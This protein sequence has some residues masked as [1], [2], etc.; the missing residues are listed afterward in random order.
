[1]GSAPRPDGKRGVDVKSVVLGCVQ[2]GE[3]TGQFA[4]ALRRLSDQ[5]THLYV[6]GSQYWYS[7]IPNVTRIAADRAASNYSDRDADDE[8][9]DRIAAQRDRGNFVA[10]HPF[11]AGP[12]DV[13]DNDDG[14]HLVVL[15]PGATHSTGDQNSPAIK[16]AER[17]VTQRDAGPRLNQNLLVFVAAAA[18]RLVEL[19]GA[20]RSFLAWQSIV[21]DHES[22]DLTFQQRQQAD[23]KLT[24]ASKQVDSLIAE[25]FTQVLVPSRAPGTA[26]LDWQ[27]TRA[28]TAGDIGERISRKLGTEEKLIGRYAGVRVRMDLDRH[29]LW[30]E[31]GDV[32][33]GALWEAYARYPYMPRL[34]SR[35]V[36]D[37]AVSDGASKINW[38][39]ETFAYAEAHDGDTWVG[40]CT[41]QHVTPTISGLLLH[42]DHIPAPSTPEGPGDDEPIGPGGEEPPGGRQEPGG[43]V[44]PEPDDDGPSPTQFYAQFQLDRVRGAQ[45]L[46]DILEHIAAHLGPE[47]QLELELRASSADGYDD[48]TR[49]TV[50]ENAQSLNAQ[51]AEFE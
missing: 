48:G 31:R 37:H 39:H 44:R 33:I 4:D 20:A 32:S 16:L 27:S 26:D 8:V 14:A 22:L 10:V 49:R 18:N 6:D 7:L 47:I 36:L 28:S 43:G 21:K 13:P 29:H 9:R 5:A 38:Q 42:P 41:A 51:S 12:G 30:T 19:R 45:Q 11:A 23:S 2:P 35:D 46:G 3:P 40:I 34:T 24:D 50:S 25:T 1:M 17:I 15:E